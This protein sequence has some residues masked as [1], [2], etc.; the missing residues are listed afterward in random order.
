MRDISRQNEYVDTQ[1]QTPWLFRVILFVVC[2]FVFQQKNPSPYS[3]NW[4]LLQRSFSA[5]FVFRLLK[6]LS[7]GYEWSDV[8]Y[9]TFDILLVSNGRVGILGL[10]LVPANLGHIPILGALLCPPCSSHHGGLLIVGNIGDYGLCNRVTSDHAKEEKN[11]CGRVAQKSGVAA[12]FGIQKAGSGRDTGES[13]C[14]IKLLLAD[15]AL[16]PPNATLLLKPS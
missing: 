8:K 3:Y 5:L 9:F 16:P 4:R 15:N 6:K 12:V 14:Q 1:R 10:P 11:W 13:E 7:T 2:L